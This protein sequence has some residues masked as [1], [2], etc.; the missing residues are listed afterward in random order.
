MVK[1]RNRQIRTANRKPA[2]FEHG[3]S[4]GR[5]HFMHQMQVDI[6]NSR[7]FPGFLDGDMAPPE[8]IEERKRFHQLASSSWAAPSRGFDA[9]AAAAA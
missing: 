6:E 8:L 2:L 3:E 9:L 4:L 1:R 5:G 7:A